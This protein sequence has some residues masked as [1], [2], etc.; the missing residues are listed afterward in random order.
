[1]ERHLR[2]MVL[3]DNA[4]ERQKA[5]EGLYRAGSELLVSL[6]EAQKHFTSERHQQQFLEFKTLYEQYY[7]HIGEMI[8]L[9]ENGDKHQQSEAIAILS[10]PLFLG[11]SDHAGEILNSLAIDKE[12]EAREVA[13]E[14]KNITQHDEQMTFSFAFFS[15]VFGGLMSWLIIFSIERPNK[16]LQHLIEQLANGKLHDNIPYLD[17]Q[18]ES[19]A[20]ARALESLQVVCQ[21]LEQERWTKENVAKI[22][23]DLQQA[24][25]FLELSQKFLSNICPLLEVGHG[26]FYI[27]SDDKLRILSGY[28]YRERKNLNQYF[29]VGEGLIG[30]CAMEKQPIVLT[31]PPADYI[32]I[33]SGLGEATPTS[34]MV[35]P[36]LHSDCLVGVLE[37]AAFKNFSQAEQSLIDS[38][39]PML[40]MSLE[41][42]ERN[43]RTQRLLKESQAQT[44][45][46]K[47]QARQLEEQKFELEAQHLELEKMLGDSQSKTEQVELLARQLE[48]QK[49]E[50]EAQ[51]TELQKLLTESHEK[52]EQMELQNRRLEDQTFELEAQ[53][54]EIQQT[55]KWYLSII[56]FAPMGVCV[57]N[58][59]GQIV[60]CNPELERMFGYEVGELLWKNID[61]LTPLEIRP[62]H[63]ELRARFMNER[64]ARPM[65]YGLEL[66][67]I[68]K[69]NSEFPVE[70]GLAHLPDLEGG[71]KNVC[72]SVRDTSV[73]K[74]AANEILKAKE[75]AESAT[76][77]K[78]DFLANMSH[79]IRTPM[80]AI[81]GLSYLALK[82]D[83]TTHQRDYIRKIQNSGQHLLGIINDILDFS[84]IEAGKLSVEKNE[85]Q[86]DTVLGNLV[87]L[88]AE[89]A[90]DKGLELIFDI[91]KDVPKTLVGDSLRLGQ[92]LIN[93]AN[94][95][96]KFTEVGEVIVEVKVLRKDEQDVMLHFAVRDTGIGLSSEQK[97]KLFQS[98]QQADTSTSRKYG[99][100]GLGLAI[101][102]QLAELMGGAVGVESELGKGS[103]FWFTAQLGIGQEKTQKLLP[104][105]D[106][107]GRRVLVVDDNE[108]ARMI[109]C[110]MLESM[111]FNV[112]QVANGKAALVM[113]RAAAESDIAYDIVFL[114]WQM[115][116]MDG[117][118]T[119]KA[120][121]LLPLATYP[122]LVMVT[123]YG[124]EELIH[125]AELEGIRDVLIKPINASVLFDTV[126]QI[127]GHTVTT[128][129]S[130]LESSAST[131]NLSTI[132]GAKI[133]VVEDNELNQEVAMGLLM[134]SGFEVDIA[135]NGQEAV[136]KIHKKTYD[137]VLMDMQ[138]PIMDGISATIEIRKDEK[139]HKLPIVAMTANAMMQ[140]R[141]KCLQAG[142]NDHVSKPIDPDAL[143]SALLKWIPPKQAFQSLDLADVEVEKIPSQ[144][145]NLPPIS[146][147][148]D[149]EGLPL[150][151]GIDTALGLKR[152][153]GK[154]PLYLNMLRKYVINQE[155]TPRE[156]RAALK[157]SN[158]Q[159][160][161]RIV[162][163]AK[164]V[165]G[166]I[167]AVGLQKM[168]EELEQMIRS[169][170]PK[171]ILEARI[172]SF[173]KVQSAMIDSLR[174]SLS[175]SEKETPKTIDALDTSKAAEI[176]NHLSTLLRDD[177]SEAGNV[178]EENV[179]LLRFLL[180][181]ESFSKVDAA[182]R[183]FDFEN[184][185]ELLKE[186]RITLNLLE[187]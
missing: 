95:A 152:V 177:D 110:D 39:I 103:T 88:I 29:S 170:V 156:L 159:L 120:I 182:I 21:G 43:V 131:Q 50:L 187:S 20:I 139:F 160:A 37:L 6:E 80:N 119:S 153:L 154:K 173:E 34:I 101:S 22:S 150:I 30:Q 53:Q 72:V 132:A 85:F 129:S 47:T 171:D 12:E 18:N 44:E 89:K 73:A 126:M 49:F 105:P 164:G 77:M 19:G 93:Y 185:F 114:D 174:V 178:L 124:R 76:K 133:L 111:T 157:Q 55:E 118:E 149:E 91:D 184:A 61:E 179:D 97:E 28:G 109:F 31:H 100:T 14:F 90:N 54:K 181:A 38:L 141:E 10:T 180:G 41:I 155:H 134:E 166:N 117:I 92:I 138:M 144:S 16:K 113:I 63:P 169:K 1:M 140:D 67:G 172:T 94:N 137:I 66:R 57:V 96:I 56:E 130:T 69:D 2:Q 24:E 158:L 62:R 65:A 128:S 74:N 7:H 106:L 13:T 112:D 163:S 136:L 148:M 9:V 86:F 143:F 33:S 146:V 99:G 186:R 51:H 167:G 4:P 5:H 162:H 46:M 23:N 52:S 165:S 107:R 25:S 27:Y 151:G 123:A 127:L 32:T 84:K 82:T 48:E 59:A 42:L 125:E 36:I 70:V 79:E 17:F 58:E 60:L 108:Y 145:Q 71:M 3:A 40:A 15:L 116:E 81:I 161:E 83:L 115:P 176:L 147:K 183:N 26:V 87:S 102:K 98:F 142:M 75:L 45:L 122:Y 104:A 11:L 175:A 135:N 8:R 68:R 78:S 168:A 35:L 121:H 64:G